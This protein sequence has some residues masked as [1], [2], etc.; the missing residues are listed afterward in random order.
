MTHIRYLSTIKPTD[1]CIAMQ[2]LTNVPKWLHPTQYPPTWLHHISVP[3]NMAT[4]QHSTQQHGYNTPQY[5]TTWLQ[6]TTVP[7]NMATTQHNTYQYGYNT[8]QYPPTW[9]QHNTVP[10]KMATSHLSTKQHG[11]NTRVNKGNR[12]IHLVKLKLTYVILV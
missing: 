11:Y 8:P 7:N 5:P 3:T 2:S 12:F 4:S 10:N 6:H 1:R 9:L